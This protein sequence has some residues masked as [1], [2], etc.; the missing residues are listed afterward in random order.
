MNPVRRKF[1]VSGFFHA[2]TQFHFP[3]FVGTNFNC[4][5]KE[6]CDNSFRTVLQG[7]RISERFQLGLNAYNVV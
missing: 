7:S 4:V 1:R 5:R 6:N 2:D 3:S